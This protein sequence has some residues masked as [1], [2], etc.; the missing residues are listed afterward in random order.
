MS[1]RCMALDLEAVGTTTEPFET[2]LSHKETILYAL[3]VGARAGEL[4]Y[5]YEGRG[6]NVLPTYAVVPTLQPVAA[7]FGGLGGNLL[8]VVHGGQW[9]RCHRPF[10]AEDRLTSVGKVDGVYDLKRMATAEISTETRDANGELVCETRWSILFRFDGGFDGPPPPRSEKVR[11]PERAPDF[12]VAEKTTAEQALLYRLNGD[13]NPLHA[14]PEIG[15][16]AGFPGTILHGLCTYGYV[17]RAVL[18]AAGGGDPAKLKVLAGQFRKPVFPGDTIV[19]EGWQEDGR[20][21]L[22][23]TVEDRPED[24]V[25]ANAYAEL[26]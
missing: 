26:G 24:I 19:T 5:L 10:S 7:L 4:D 22:K 20:V 16:S 2:T 18:N 6:P 15:K 8:G 25:F 3:G 23:V 12:R 21:V 11:P 14:D 13:F 1:H 9:I 17:G